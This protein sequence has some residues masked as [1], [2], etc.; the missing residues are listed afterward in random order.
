MLLVISTDSLGLNF[1]GYNLAIGVL[2]PKCDSTYE[3]PQKHKA[4][5]ASAKKLGYL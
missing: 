1:Q 2:N 3:Y 5:P 4:L